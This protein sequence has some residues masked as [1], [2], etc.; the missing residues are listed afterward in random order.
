MT[1]AK[2]R[3]HALSQQLVQGIPDAGNFED[4]PRIRKVAPESVGQ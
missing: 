2:K 4:I 1:S 3:L